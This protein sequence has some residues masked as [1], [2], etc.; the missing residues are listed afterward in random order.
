MCVCVCV[1]RPPPLGASFHG[2]QVPCPVGLPDG[3]WRGLEARVPEPGFSEGAGPP[4]QFGWALE[5]PGRANPPFTPVFPFLLTA[6]PW[7]FMWALAARWGHPGAP[8]VG[9][10]VCARSQPALRRGP[11]SGCRGLALV[12][13]RGRGGYKAAQTRGRMGSPVRAKGPGTLGAGGG[14]EGPQRA[15]SPPRGRRLWASTP[16]PPGRSAVAPHGLVGG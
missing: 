7:A 5:T 8:G 2:P 10:V 11:S 1:W 16:R 12:S 4:F 13:H 3:L 15:P 9:R 6:D 14:D